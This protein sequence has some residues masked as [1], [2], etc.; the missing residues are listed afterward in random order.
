MKKK[1]KKIN[2]VHFV[3][4]I[5]YFD[6]LVWFSY[7]IIGF[8]K[9]VEKSLFVII[10]H[11]S[12]FYLHYLLILPKLFESKKYF[13]YS[14]SILLL[15]IFVS[16]VFYLMQE[17]FYNI[18]DII[19][20]HDISRL[21]E[22][23]RDRMNSRREMKAYEIANN[24]RLFFRMFQNLVFVIIILLVSF[25]LRNNINSR[26]R[27]KETVELK[28]QILE[29]ES[30]MLKWQMNPHFLFNILNNIYSLSHLKSDKTP[31]SIHR[32]SEMLRYV[33]Y[34]CNE[35]FVKVNQ[36]LDYIKAYIELQLLKDDSLKRNVKYS[37]ENKNSSL[38][39]APMLLIAFVENSFKHSKIEDV[40][41]GWIEI[42]L[43]TSKEQI[44]FSVENSI[45][46]LNYTKD[47]T[48]G[49]GLENVKRRL[50]LLYSNKYSLAID[51]K[52]KTYSV[53]LIISI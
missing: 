14:L 23:I 31:D 16:L 39:I 12:V 42:F 1:L 29:A 8:E 37:F 10:V 20:K 34:D 18:K 45:P 36:E 35:K 13:I 27:E 5:I 53:N 43:K 51:Q 32:L 26:K 49:V 22:D 41:N 9:A 17:Y 2:I 4:W 38:Q 24:S 11:L 33:I 46:D 30:K 7:D 47:M 48:N 28:T 44:V 3:L 15:L 21:P 40:E 19:M 50:K 52:N 6:L 25:V